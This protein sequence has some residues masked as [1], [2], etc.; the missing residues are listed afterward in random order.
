M[1]DLISLESADLKKTVFQNTAVTL[2]GRAITL[3]LGLGASVLLVRTLGREQYGQYASFYAYLALFCWLPSLGME[4]VIVRESSIQTEKEGSIFGTSVLLSVG[5]S[6]GATLIALLSSIF[7][8]YADGYEILLFVAALDTLL[9]TPLRLTALIFHTRLKHGYIIT[10]SI[11]RQTLW[12]FAIII[13]S[14]HDANLP[15]IIWAHFFCSLLEFST[16]FFFARKFVS[17]NWRWNT[18]IARDLLKKSWPLVLSAAS[19]AIYNR[20]D[21]TMLH[22]LRTNQELGFY[23][24]AVNITEAFVILPLA[25]MTAMLPILSKSALQ[26]ERFEHYTALCFRYVM[27]PGFWICLLVTLISKPLIFILY[28]AEF[29]PSAEVLQLLIWSELA[30]FFGSVMTHALI[31][32]ELQMYSF[33]SM[34]LGALVN[35]FLNFLLIPRWGIFGATWATI[36]S[37]TLAASLI[38]LFLSPT[39]RLV[40]VG[41]KVSLVPFGIAIPCVAFAWSAHGYPSMAL[42]LISYAVGTLLLKSWSLNDIRFI[43]N[44]CFRN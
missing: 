14:L 30:V 2:V 34:L 3:L 11:A 32:K 39:R 33:I 44:I 38:F 41:I 21:Q 13:A 29:E 27:V 4:Q 26:T 42:I 10:A 36:V 20:I 12:L 5:L 40:L 15:I 22:K 43:R 18:T 25:L 19:F 35:I 7:W 28:G 23:A 1:K 37:H 16:L 31:A 6:I 17:F 8:H 9:L 24:T